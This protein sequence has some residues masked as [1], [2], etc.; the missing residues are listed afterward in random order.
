MKHK[1][2]TRRKHTDEPKQMD[3]K[4]VLGIIV[5]FVVIAAIV[6][7]LSKCNSSGD[8]SSEF[9]KMTGWQEIPIPAQKAERQG[10]I[11]VIQGSLKLNADPNI[12]EGW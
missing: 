8:K 9:S 5:G 3:V 10:D 7:L 4:K 12:R 6:S 2:S 11:K 1:Y